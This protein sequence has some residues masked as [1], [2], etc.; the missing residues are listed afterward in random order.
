PEEAAGLTGTRALVRGY[1]TLQRAPGQLLHKRDKWSRH[2]VEC[3]SGSGRV[4]ADSGRMRWEDGEWTDGDCGVCTT[5]GGRLLAEALGWPGWGRSILA[6][7]ACNY[8]LRAR[9]GC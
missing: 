4:A 1:S 7:R 6:W 5:A 3:A 8:Q 9:A 2:A